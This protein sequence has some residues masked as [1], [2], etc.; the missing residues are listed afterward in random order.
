MRALVRPPASPRLAFARQLHQGSRSPARF[1]KARIRPP[2]LPRLPLAPPLHLGSTAGGTEAAPRT[3]SIPC[4][5]SL[6]KKY[7]VH[8][9]WP[10]REGCELV[11]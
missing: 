6:E 4:G 2:V 11:N 3:H 8:V 5:D 9:F 7:R 10:S 1:T